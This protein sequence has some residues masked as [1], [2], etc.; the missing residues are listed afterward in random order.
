VRIAFCKN[1]ETLRLA[2]ERLAG[3]RPR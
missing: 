1:L 3:L 2:C